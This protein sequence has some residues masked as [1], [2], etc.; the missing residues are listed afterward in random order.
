MGQHELI[1]AIMAALGVL[2]AISTV[3]SW[4]TRQQMMITKLEIDTRLTAM[5]LRLTEK[6][7]ESYCTWHAHNELNAKVTTLENRITWAPPQ[8]RD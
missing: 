7:G 1:E 2:T 6:I 4:L 3:M 8:A 5:E